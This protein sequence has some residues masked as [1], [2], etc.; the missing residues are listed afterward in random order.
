MSIQIKGVA[1]L[2]ARLGKLVAIQVLEPPM[3]RA[4]Y[5]L[6]AAMQD[7]PAAPRGS[8]Y[9]RTGTLGR[10]WTTRITRSS[11]GITGTVGNNTAYG[12]LVQSERFQT[13]THKRTGWTT[14]ERAVK[15]NEKAIV[16][17][18]QRAIQAA[19]R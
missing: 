14:D 15:D 2:I 3:Q 16:D 18:F 17:D 7:Y 19:L 4:V 9:I 11:N 12:P 10:R 1:E 5:R 13:R 8:R 6:Q